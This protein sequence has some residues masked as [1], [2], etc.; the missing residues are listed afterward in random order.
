M[1]RIFDSLIISGS[2]SFNDIIMIFGVCFE[3]Y[4]SIACGAFEIKTKNLYSKIG[5]LV[6][7]LHSHVEF[8]SNVEI[9]LTCTTTQTHRQH[10]AHHHQFVLASTPLYNDFVV[11]VLGEIF[12][13]HFTF[14]HF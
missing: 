11:K 7:N 8:S 1:L 2:S 12:N 10:V 3:C 9:V 6:A 5:L 4:F 14:S 13:E